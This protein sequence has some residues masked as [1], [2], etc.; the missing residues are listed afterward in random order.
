MKLY[1][2]KKKIFIVTWKMQIMRTQKRVCK[3][4]EIKSIG[5]YH[6]CMFKAI[7]YC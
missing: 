2:L 1:H 4:F 6:D 3:D 7:H 5:E